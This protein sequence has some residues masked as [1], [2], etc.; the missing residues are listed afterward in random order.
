VSTGYTGICFDKPTGRECQ[1]E[2]AISFR[3]ANVTGEQ[4]TVAPHGYSL[5]NVKRASRLLA[6]VLARWH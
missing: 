3:R 6:N 5:N 4:D 1:W 2:V